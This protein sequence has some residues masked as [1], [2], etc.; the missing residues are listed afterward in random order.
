MAE[1]DLK[2]KYN[3]GAAIQS[4]IITDSNGVVYF[5][6]KT[7]K[8]IA[9]NSDGTLKWE[10]SGSFYHITGLVLSNDESVVFAVDGGNDV[11][12]IYTATGNKKWGYGVNHGDSENPGLSGIVVDANDNVYVGSWCCVEGLYSIDYAGNFRWDLGGDEC[13]SGHAI[14]K[15]NTVVYYL[16][17]DF[18]LREVLLSD[19]TI[20]WLHAGLGHG[21]YGTGISIAS[22][23]TI[24]YGDCNYFYAVNP[25]GSAKWNFSVSGYPTIGN[26]IGSNS[27]IWF[28]E[29]NY[30]AAITKIFVV[31]P[32][33]SEVWHYDMPNSVG[34][35]RAGLNLALDS[36]DTVFVGCND[37]K[38]H[39][40]NSDGT[41][42][43]N[44]TAGNK[45]QSGIAFS[46][47]E[48][49]VYFGCDDGYLYAIEAKECGKVEVGDKVFLLPIGNFFGDIVALK[50]DV[51]STSD[52]AFLASLDEKK[53]LKLAFKSCTA[54][55]NDKVI[56]TPIEGMKENIVAL[57]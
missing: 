8:V 1:G 36:N 25:D 56:C 40:I 31:N 32:S 9:L 57:R 11:Y 21:C 52:K 55:V 6:T 41:L 48:D 50:S 47:S 17:V 5:G 26:A 16:D 14:G 33:G 42:R 12:A 30:G 46:S 34:P 20:N 44:Y 19:G 3:A 45:I 22:D 43:W 27:D 4:E 38:L 10:F 39:A 28:V 53:D 49:T 2:W 35:E 51:F 23:G 7:T 15:S 29:V 37:Y 54:K 24:Y 13:H 18:G